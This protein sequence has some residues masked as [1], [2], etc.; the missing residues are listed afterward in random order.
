MMINNIG[1]VLL[2]LLSKTLGDVCDG[3]RFGYF[4]ISWNVYIY[5]DG[6]FNQDTG[7]QM[8]LELSTSIYTGKIQCRN[9]T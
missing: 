5:E 3:D 7:L 2:V 6:R 4:G 8:N 1:F 9:R